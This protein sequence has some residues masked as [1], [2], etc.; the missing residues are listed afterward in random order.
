MNGSPP[1]PA[2]R[3]AAPVPAQAAAAAAGLVYAAGY[4]A[5]GLAAPG[6]AA[7]A[8]SIVLV[9]AALHALVLPLLLAV[10]VR[11]MAQMLQA[12][13]LGPAVHRFWSRQA[14]TALAWP[15]A[16]LVGWQAG[17]TPALTLAA[18]GAYL[19]GQI[20]VLYLALEA[21]QRE[22]VNRS[23][24]YVAAL[25][26][27]SGFAAL[28]YQVVWQRILFS[29]F[30]V[31]SESVT[32]IVSVFMAGLGIGALAGGWLQ[33]LFPRRLLEIF[34]G[35]E[36]GIGLFGLASVRLI[37]AVSPTGALTVPD[38]IVRVYAVLVV[39]TLL[40][41]ATLPVLIAH[42]QRHFRDIGRTVSLLYALN[43]LGSAVAAFATVQLLFVL[44]G[45]RSSIA[46]AVICNFATA[47]LLFRAARSLDRAPGHAGATD[48]ATAREPGA[49]ARA[50]IPY[51]LAV[52][53]L[54]GV[55][56]VSLSLEI[57]WF[58]LLG[59]L[60]GSRPE[61]FG[62]L[63]SVYLAGMAWGAWNAE[64]QSQDDRLARRLAVRGLVWAAFAAF[65]VL[66]L[67]SWTTALAGKGV[68]MAVGYAG[69]GLVAYWCGRTFPTLVQ[70]GM[71]DSASSAALPVATLYFANIVGATFG[72][73][74]TGFVLLDRFPLSTSMAL[75][76]LATMALAAILAGRELLLA[77]RGPAAAAAGLAVAAFA[78]HGPLHSGY[79]ER[80][81]YASTDARPFRHVRQDRTSII[82]V[83]AARRDV[84][85]GHGIYDG[86]F[87]IDPVDNS[88]LVDRA[89][90]VAALHP[91]PRRI[92]EI[93]LSTGSWTRVLASYE[94]VREVIVV[95]IGRSYQTL[96]PHYPE[97]A[98]VL[99][100]PKVRLYV[101]DGRRWLR[102]HP[103]E[104]FDLIVMN[105]TYPWRA[106]ATNLLSREFLA[107]ARSRLRPGGV[108]YYNSVGYEHVPYTAAHVFRHVTR[109]STT[110]AASDAPLAVDPQMRR[111]NL[112][113]FRT[114]EGASVFLASDAHR[115]KL[116]QL[117]EAP[118]PELGPAL[119][120]RRDLRL[121]T[122][123]N[124]AT[125]FKVRY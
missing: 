84:V 104:Q 120:A 72:P 115:R 102:N 96:L 97:V 79:L 38:L 60:S 124:M 34:V 30:G 74:V 8:P 125:E 58:R 7:G 65:A 50:P 52:L 44:G 39:P 119:L 25:F 70:L 77:R 118:L 94:P 2:A 90:M 27:L 36:V 101:D 22:A 54:A 3:A 10:L 83:E 100:D 73:L 32:A 99:T 24:R 62:M 28:I 106:N 59:F 86:R 109:Y 66:P 78:L 53:G 67:V 21:A 55:G 35:L 85:F 49:P 75:L 40:M 6:E 15:A 64:R 81:Q 111:R 56:F 1:V 121:T 33:R 89:Y 43:T 19:G 42:L 114:P 26:F 71:R 45:L 76:A 88:N 113:R 87:N 16:A 51:A 117:V 4:L 105:T 122:D 31:N 110:I 93:G 12:P 14:W 13:R 48:A 41:G 46:V 103:H 68:G 116:E 123:D 20:A 47:W 11:S 92:L 57:L 61:V 112:L 69:A 29:Q 17:F 108:L 23:E 98:S 80:L 107:L 63:L 95:E 9:E 82:T 91:E 37:E 18:L 5:Q